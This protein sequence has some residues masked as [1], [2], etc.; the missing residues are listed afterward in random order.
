MSVVSSNPNLLNRPNDLI[1]EDITLV[2]PS[3]A[4]DPDKISLNIL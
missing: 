1:I 4:G 2:I 3:G